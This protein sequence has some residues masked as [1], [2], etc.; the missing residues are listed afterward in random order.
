MYL[1]KRFQPGDVLFRQGDPSDHV[2]L[3]RSGCAEV[4][5]EVGED[6][7]LLG[8]AKEGEFLGEM[9]VLDERPRSATV[10]AASELEVELISRRG[11]LERVSGDAQLAHRLLVRMSARLR[12]VEDML[13][14]LHTASAEARARAQGATAAQALPNIRLEATTYAAML[15]VGAKPI[16]IAGL[17][18]VVGRQSDIGEPDAG[19]KPDLEIPDPKPYRLSRQHFGILA[20][21]GTVQV[22]DLNSELGT[23]VNE[24]PLGRDFAQDR[25]P[26]LQGENTVIAGGRG[27]P[28]AF[29]VTLL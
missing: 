21:D 22:R 3:V 5:R 27:S 29:A 6:Y 28:Y 25:I 4:L 12:D 14:T 19:S 16:R 18:Y 20:E 10:R 8:M 26:L 9:G 24:I 7:I 17:P 11:F 15:Y 23:I 13:A 1:L 2:V